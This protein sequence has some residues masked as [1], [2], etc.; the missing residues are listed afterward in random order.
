L[1]DA[2]TEPEA[3]GWKRDPSG[4]FAGRYWDGSAWTEHVVGQDRVRSIDP[5]PADPAPTAPEP[6][7]SPAPARRPATSPSRAW[8]AW[9]LWA[10]V[11]IPA[12]LVIAVVFALT[13]GG[14]DDTPATASG[15]SASKTFAIGDTARSDAFDVTVYGFKNPQAPGQFLKPSPG[16]HYVSVDVQLANRGTSQQNF[17]SLLQVHLLDGSNRQFDPT[18]GEIAPPAP[19]GEIPPG[20]AI[21]GQVLFE[22]P[23]ATTGLRVRVQG[24]LTAAGAYFTLA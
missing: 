21:R 23:D 22:I 3:A 12:V 2:V 17:S 13:R 11:A 5:L 15:P 18:F 16:S 14:D 10:R 8:R 19:D 6:V 9:P 20:Q 7:K 24:S 1:A 4:R